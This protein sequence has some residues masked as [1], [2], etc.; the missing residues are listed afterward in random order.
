MPTHLQMKDSFHHLFMRID[1]ILSA[2][3]D[4]LKLAK[5]S[6][7]SEQLI[8]TMNKNVA[9]MIYEALGKFTLDTSARTNHP[10]DGVHNYFDTG[11]SDIQIKKA[12]LGIIIRDENL[13]NSTIDAIRSLKDTEKHREITGA[14][15]KLK[16]RLKAYIVD[17]LGIINDEAEKN[18][19]VRYIKQQVRSRLYYV[20]GGTEDSYQAFA[21]S[22]FP[23]R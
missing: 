19:S 12:A 11:L 8:Y 9:D 13:E 15:A 16:E 4:D 7:E 18:A 21:D 10:L 17:M 6:K 23:T 3:G 20:A 22:L 1:T 2:L 14:I 5:F